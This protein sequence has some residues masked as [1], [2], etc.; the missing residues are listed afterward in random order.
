MTRILA[1]C[2]VVAVLLL[3]MSESRAAAPE[4]TFVELRTLAQS[5]APHDWTTAHDLLLNPTISLFTKLT[6]IKLLG[7]NPRHEWIPV[8]NQLSNSSL[9]RMAA[10]ATKTLYK[11][12]APGYGAESLQRVQSLGIP[13]RDALRIRHK[14]GQWTYNADAQTLFLAGVQSRHP[15]IQI[16]SAVGLIEIGVASGKAYD[17]LRNVLLSAERWDDRLMAVNLVRKLSPWDGAKALLKLATKDKNKH[18][19]EA[20]IDALRPP[21][22]GAKP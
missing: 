6:F 11:W 4:P 10:R 17:T 1:P 3:P 22:T 19:A 12:K 21:K 15:R 7:P 2:M 9:D 18:V 8:L 20:A 16:D 14:K 13:V 5:S